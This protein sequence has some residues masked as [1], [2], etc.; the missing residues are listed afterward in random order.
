MICLHNLYIPVANI[1]PW[2]DS[3][4]SKGQIELANSTN[5]DLISSFNFIYARH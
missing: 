4:V 5:S 2:P 3:M 1:M